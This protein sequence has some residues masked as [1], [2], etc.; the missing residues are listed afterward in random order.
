[1][2]DLPHPSTRYGPQTGLVPT[3][4]A[5]SLDPSRPVSTH[6]CGVSG[7]TAATSGEGA[8]LGRAG[9]VRARRVRAH[10]RGGGPS[11]GFGSRPGAGPLRSGRA[12]HGARW[13]G[14]RVEQGIRRECSFFQRSKCSQP[15]ATVRWSRTTRGP[16]TVEKDDSQG[17]VDSF[18]SLKSREHDSRKKHE[19]TIATYSICSC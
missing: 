12:L 3:H 8:A 18:H 1:M 11:G 16:E 10:H 2:L 15:E 13:G 19:K 7:S 6:V 4:L 5:A 17:L 14:A 9:E